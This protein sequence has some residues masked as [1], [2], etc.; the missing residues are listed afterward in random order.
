[1]L[2]FST[3]ISECP[4]IADLAGRA[5]LGI[6]LGRGPILASGRISLRPQC[7]SLEANRYT[8][9]AG[10]LERR[11]LVRGH[12]LSRF[13][14]DRRVRFPR[15]PVP[16]LLLGCF[17]LLSCEAKENPAIGSGTSM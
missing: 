6:S 1:M 7:E 2:T 17:G 13:M 9:C 16:R 10:A 14:E 11:R 3:V 4:Q 12:S 8:G 5:L 15:G